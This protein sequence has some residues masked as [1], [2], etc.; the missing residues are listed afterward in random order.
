MHYGQ[1]K[2]WK[3]SEL[4]QW[5]LDLKRG[6]TTYCTER[7]DDSLNDKIHEQREILEKS[8]TFL[9]YISRKIMVALF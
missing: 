4:R 3:V 1:E 7:T 8:L 9:A 6:N 2:I 5:E